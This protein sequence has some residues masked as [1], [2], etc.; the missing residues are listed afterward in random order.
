MP[1]LR[2][3][4]LTEELGDMSEFDNSMA[5]AIEEELNIL[6]GMDEL[7]LLTSDPND[8]EVRARRRF[9]IAIARGVVRHLRDNADAFVVTVEDG[10]HETEIRADQFP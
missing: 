5:A 2:P 10:T 8:G 6:L 4:N 9:V 3:G 1:D 7:P